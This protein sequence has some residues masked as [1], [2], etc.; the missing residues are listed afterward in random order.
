MK[1]QV[2]VPI[3]VDTWKSSVAS[4]AIEA[5]ASIINDVWGLRRDP[6][7]AD[8][9][10]KTGS[11]LIMMFN[12]TDPVFAPKSEDIVSD[13]VKYLT[14]SIRTA[15]NAGVKDDQMMI[16]PGIGFG[17]TTQESLLLIRSLPAFKKMGF[18]VLIGPSRKRFIGDVLDEP[19]DRRIIGTVAACCIGSCL[20]AS[21]VRVHDVL[22][23]TDENKRRYYALIERGGHAD[24][25]SF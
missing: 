21:A 12:A 22:E 17:V 15:R 19:V 23:V 5:G 1:R 18:P 25:N 2:S 10:S 7:V 4:A 20:G 6:R 24:E 16:D 14:E 8:I 3:S 9:A 13:A 11:G